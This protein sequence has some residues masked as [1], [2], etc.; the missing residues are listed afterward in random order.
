MNT[1][2]LGG[3]DVNNSTTSGTNTTKSC[4]DTEVIPDELHNL[5]ENLKKFVKEQ[6]E[7]RE[8]NCCQRFSIEPILQV[9][10]ELDE[11]IKNEL[12]KIDIELQR[13]SKVI[14]SLKKETNQLLIDAEMAYRLVKSAPPTQSDL[15]NNLTDHS[16]NPMVSKYFES[17]IQKFEEKME[18]YSQQIKDLENH[19]NNINKPYNADELFLIMKKQHETLI[20]FASELYSIQDHLNSR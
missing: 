14:D 4:K 3:I 15:Y 17:M 16:R 13:N 8:E 9:E 11:N 1:T 7:I 5:V 18:I 2:G 19:L 12:N 6:K 10:T 20:A